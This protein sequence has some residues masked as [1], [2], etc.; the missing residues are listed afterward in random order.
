[1][2]LKNINPPVDFIANLWYGD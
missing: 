1:M 2:I